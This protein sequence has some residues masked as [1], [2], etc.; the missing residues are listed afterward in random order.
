MRTL[1][2]KNSKGIFMNLNEECLLNYLK[3]PD[4][5]SYHSDILKLSNQI[6]EQRFLLENF[7][8]KNLNLSYNDKG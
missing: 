1:K 6:M 8:S 5:L 3:K 2:R 4:E 7:L